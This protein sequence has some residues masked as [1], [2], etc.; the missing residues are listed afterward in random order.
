MRFN[1]KNSTCEITMGEHLVLID[2]RDLLLFASHSWYPAA[3]VTNHYLRTSIAKDGK[4]TTVDFHILL[5]KPGAETEV[6]HVNGNGLDNRRINLRVVSHLMNCNNSR[7]R[8]GT[9][10]KYRGVCLINDGR[11]WTATVT[12]NNQN[13]Y[14]GCWPTELEAALAYNDF[15]IAN[16]LPKILN[17]V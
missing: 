5:M 14:L 1:L 8:R 10:S 12:F 13:K 2:R 9:S 4:R 3:N 7:Q 11:A 16:N 6:D 17:P 15:I